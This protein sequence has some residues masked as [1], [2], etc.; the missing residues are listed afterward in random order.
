MVVIREL[1]ITPNAPPEDDITLRV[2]FTRPEAELESPHSSVLEEPSSENIP[3]VNSPIA[4]PTTNDKDTSTGY[5]LLFR[6]NRG[7]P[8]NRY[9]Q[10]I[11]E[12]RSKYPIANYVST[13]GL[14]SPSKHLRTKFPHA[15]FPLV[16]KK[17]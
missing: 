16:S 2:T 10:E 6:N 12:Q 17:L 3:E 14:L 8:L 5:I 15:L 13:K 1:D 7:K 11:E 9:S 4:P